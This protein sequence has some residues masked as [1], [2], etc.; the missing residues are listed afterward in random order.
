MIFGQLKTESIVQVGD[1]TR[2]DGTKSF[3]SPDEAAIT[4]IRVEPEAAA[5]FITVTSTKL[6]DWVYTTNG[7]KVVTLEITTD[8]A[9]QTFT[10]TIVCLNETEDRLFSKDEDILPIEDDIYR[11]LKAGRSSFLDKHRISQDIIVDS[12]NQRG[13]VGPLNRL[14]TKDDLFNIKEVKEWSKYLTLYLIY[15]SVQA[16]S[17]DVYQTKADNYKKLADSQS[18]RA[19]LKLDTDQDGNLDEN[20]DMQSARLV[21]R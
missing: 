12:L 19:G 17:G 3:I 21:R 14:L 5:G 18:Q 9:P 8:G 6:L 1:K 7:D 10:K 11:F 4:L 13:Y 15:S 2:L 20:I 16:E